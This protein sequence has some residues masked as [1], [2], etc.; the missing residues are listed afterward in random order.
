M[1]TNLNREEVIKAIGDMPVME[2]VKLIE[3]MEDKFNVSAAQAVAVAA[4]AAGAEGAGAAA[5]EKTEFTVK[6]TSFGDKKIGV[7]KVVRSL[8]G[9]PLKE[10]KDL[11]EGVPS[12]LKENV[13]K[14]DADEIKKSIEEA[15]GAV[16]V[17]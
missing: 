8:T 12:V 5:A 7:I 14:E 15:G 4:P 13:S 1:S 9:L 6:L 16:S 2:L 11:V 17:E 3:E 10:A